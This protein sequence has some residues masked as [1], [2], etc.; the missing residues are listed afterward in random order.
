VTTRR[1]ARSEIDP[2]ICFPAE[3]GVSVGLRLGAV[4]AKAGTRDSA[5][6]AATILLA[7][8]TRAAVGAWRRKPSALI[9]VAAEGLPRE[10]RRRLI[11]E[12][13][14]WAALDDDGIV[15]LA[16]TFGGIAGS[17]SPTLVDLDVAVLVLAERC[18]E[19]EASQ[20]ELANAISVLPEAEPIIVLG[21]ATEPPKRTYEEEALSRLT[22]RERE[23][24][25]LVASG[26][27]TR[28]IA[29]VLVISTKTVKTHVQNLLAKLG[30]GSRLEAV[31]L[32][33][34][35]GRTTPLR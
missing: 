19:V 9:F 13:S 25:E 7:D 31:A 27:G 24:L 3:H 6:A 10:A 16:E 23:I 32:L 30:V 1:L 12:A 28:Q 21:E 15:K 26:L 29:D 2:Q 14:P 4:I 34:G 20:G 35:S 17:G 5:V 8:E 11:A 22:P 18:P 33:R